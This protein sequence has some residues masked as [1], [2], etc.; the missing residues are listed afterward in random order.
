MTY[1]ADRAD[2]TRLSFLD[3]AKGIGMLMIMLGHLSYIGEPLFSLCAAV[4]IAVFYIVSGFIFG[5]KESSPISKK[6]YFKKRLKTIG[7]PFLLFSL[8]AL[9]A[10]AVYAIAAGADAVS[11]LKRDVIYTL[12]L[13][14]VSTLW[15]LPTLFFADLLFVCLQKSMARIKY[16]LLIASL[17]LV[18][19]L[20]K[21]YSLVRK[22]L[23][24]MGIIGAVSECI[25]RVLLKSIVAFV[26]VVFG[27]VLYKAY[28]AFGDKK[29]IWPA[30]LFIS[31][32]AA[33]LSLINKGVDF[34]NFSLGKYPPLYIVNGCLGS[35]V[36]ILALGKL[37]QRVPMRLTGFVG[38]HSLFIMATHL[39]LKICPV[40][41][42]VS[43]G[44]YTAKS[45][46]PLYYC[47]LAL[48]LAVMLAAEYLLIRLVMAAKGRFPENSRV[49]KI[50]EYI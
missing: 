19:P 16:P 40:I 45:A 43:L 2:G 21:A 39:P 12:T 10:D 41:K 8:M 47:E 50:M 30:V 17:L 9:A 4:K 44:L 46:G 37:D 5:I 24:D 15:F 20:C 32:P 25:V 22:P 35:A 28:K 31:A 11:F 14:G 48:G 34:N 26:F 1:S 23:F 29:Y 18:Y 42:R 36:I 49:R 6:E 7:I 33:V 13:R 38:R 3:N 27:Y